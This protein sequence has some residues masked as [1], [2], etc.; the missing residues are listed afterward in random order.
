MGPCCTLLYVIAAVIAL[1]YL[2]S[3]IKHLLATP[4]FRGKK[5][6]ITGAN[7]GIG[8]ELSKRFATLGAELIISGRR[9]EELI[10]V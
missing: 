5:I 7:S 10:K 1:V 8:L 6:L 9:E 4:N 2:K 3:F